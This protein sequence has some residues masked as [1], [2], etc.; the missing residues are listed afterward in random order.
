MFSLADGTEQRAIELKMA[1][2]VV[3]S[4]FDS[5]LYWK[6]PLLA[7]SGVRIILSAGF[8]SYDYQ[9]QSRI[10]FNLKYNILRHL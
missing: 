2:R 3:E 7:L 6:E 5:H 1:E 9:V 4:Q 10:K 8:L